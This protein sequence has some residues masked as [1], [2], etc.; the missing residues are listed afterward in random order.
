MYQGI[1]PFISYSMITKATINVKTKLTHFAVLITF[2]LSTITVVA[3]DC[4]MLA[5]TDFKYGLKFWEKIN[6]QGG[7]GTFTTHNDTISVEIQNAAAKI[8]GIQLIQGNMT[9]ENG[10]SYRVTFDAAADNN[11]KIGVATSENGGSYTTY[12]SKEFEI[13]PSWNTYT[14]DFEFTHPDDKNGR[15]ELNFG[16]DTIKTNFKNIRVEALNC[17]NGEE[18]LILAPEVVAERDAFIEEINSSGGSYGVPRTINKEGYTKISVQGYVRMNLM[19]RKMTDWY[20][21]EGV[22]PKTLVINGVEK[23][24]PLGD[25]NPTGYREPLMQLA[26]AGKPTAN[27]EFGVDM[28]FD[29]QLIGDLSDDSRRLQIM[30]WIN[31][32]GKILTDYGKLSLS[33]G[34]INY[35]NMSPL[36]LWRYEIRDD[37]FYRNPW[38]WSYKSFDRYSEFYQTNAISKDA[39][40]GNVAFQG[41]VLKAEGLPKRFGAHLMIG[42]SDGSNNGFQSYLANNFKYITAG[43]LYKKIG[44]HTVGFNSYNQIGYQNDINV[45]GDPTNEEREMVYTLDGG[46]NGKR[47]TTQIEV[48]MSTFKHPFHTEYEWDPI[49]NIKTSMDQIGRTGIKPSIHLF[50]IGENFVNPNSIA[51]NTTGYGGSLKLGETTAPYYMNTNYYGGINEIGQISNNKKGASIVLNKDFG[52]L[53]ASV[54]LNVSQDAVYDENNILH[55]YI[56][57]QHYNMGV[58][59]SRF[60]Y[61]KA[62]EGPYQRTVNTWRRSFESVHIA[63]TTFGGVKTYNTLDVST[64]YK[65]RINSKGLILSNYINYNSVAEDFSITPQF[66]EK[67]FIRTFYDEFMTFYQLLPKTTLVL[68]YGVEFVKGNTQI[69]TTDEFGTKYEQE[70]PTTIGYSGGDSLT[71]NYITTPYNSEGLPIDQFGQ[72]FGI[73]LDLDITET[74]GLYIRQKWFT[75][76]DNNFL[77]DKFNGWEFSAEFKL[78]F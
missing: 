20:L 8:W 34:G 55:R 52:N 27:T 30:R 58:N 37:M 45:A 67:A 42:K 63:D 78:R 39:R 50:H 65:T 5:N 74:S 73:G 56:T 14:Y 15:L 9:Y 17:L 49:F 53:K 44:K 10:K 26:L 66:S 23:D 25:E 41:M 77:L 11:K 76:K 13:T 31:L 21:Y 72:S 40:F 29:N 60:A 69:N 46:I 16:S 6:Q 43:R 28:L 3:Q 33:F 75:H 24:T 32:N 1:K 51:N 12:S 61:Y 62:Q 35:V 22:S 4:N 2:L 70:T 36:T 71:V 64:R 57:F 38:E 47:L 68:L 54:G 48:G 19:Y 59:R 18:P 7:W